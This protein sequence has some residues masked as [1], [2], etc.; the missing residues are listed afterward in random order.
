[1]T[2]PLY[3]ITLT[4]GG[5][6]DHSA[7]S[8]S[9]TEHVLKMAIQGDLIDLYAPGAWRSVVLVQP[10]GGVVSVES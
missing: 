3:R 6:T 4:S 9:V 2:L 10:N 5:F 8:V 7:D 1:M